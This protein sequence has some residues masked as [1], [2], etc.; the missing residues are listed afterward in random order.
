[1]ES[2]CL[3]CP[4]SLGGKKSLSPFSFSLLPFGFLLSPL[5]F[6]S[7]FFPPLPSMFLPA[8]FFEEEFIEGG[9]AGF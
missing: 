8:P 9:L 1:M 2:S 6:L 7:S 5:F 3:L 4:L